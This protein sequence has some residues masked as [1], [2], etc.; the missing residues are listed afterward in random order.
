MTRTMK[1]PRKALL[2]T[3]NAELR[4][5]LLDARA[6]LAHVRAIHESVR[7]TDQA[8]HARA[9]VERVSELRQQFAAELH[10][11]RKECWEMACWG[12]GIF[13][14]LGLIV[15]GLWLP[16]VFAWLF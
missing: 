6:D 14:V 7:R 13:G 12:M 2:Y 16:G 9:M 1:K 3:A 10:E 4:A 11:A 15:G 8:S 5:D